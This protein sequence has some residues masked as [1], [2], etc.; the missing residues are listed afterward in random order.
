MGKTDK[1]KANEKAKGDKKAQ[2]KDKL[3]PKVPKALKTGGGV[4]KK[5]WSAAKSKDKLNLSVYWTKQA[6]EKLLKDLVAKE[7]YLTP[8]IVSSKLKVNVSC[9][10]EALFELLK[11]EVL[12]PV[13]EYS[14]KYCC[15]VKGP[16]FAADESKAKKEG[17]EQGKKGEYSK[18]LKNGKGKEFNYK[19]LLI[20][21]GKYFNGNRWSGK[22]KQYHYNGNV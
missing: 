17:K 11:N 9:A 19:G 6:H 12:K 15:F 1:Q 8:S 22:E 4:K 3:K 13:D 21:D 20:F 7:P 10:R 5:K 2:G 16:K 18:G 14:S